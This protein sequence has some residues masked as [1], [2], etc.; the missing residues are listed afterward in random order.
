MA[1]A[2][3]IR[4]G[5]LGGVVRVWQAEGKLVLLAPL[6]PLFCRQKDLERSFQC[7][8]FSTA[9]QKEGSLPAS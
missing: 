4:G 6:N 8:S 1:I 2:L 9:N 7:F 3:D 5:G